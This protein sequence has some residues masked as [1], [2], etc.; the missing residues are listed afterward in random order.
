MLKNTRVQYLLYICSY[1]IKKKCNYDLNNI[2]N[3]Y[4]FLSIIKILHVKFAITMHTF[5]LTLIMVKLICFISVTTMNYLHA[6]VIF[7]LK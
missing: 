2:K 4:L 3:I 7:I 5:S 1:Q 6:C